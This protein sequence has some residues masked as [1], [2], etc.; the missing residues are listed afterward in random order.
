[1][2]FSYIVQSEIFRKIS[3]MKELTTLNNKFMESQNQKR[4]KK[5]ISHVRVILI[6]HVYIAIFMGASNGGKSH[7]G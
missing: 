5:T 7:S 2:V 1:M 6:S 4:R 3:V